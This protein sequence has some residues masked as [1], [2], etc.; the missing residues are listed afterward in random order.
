MKKYLFVL[1]LFAGLCNSSIAQ[2]ETTTKVK[3]EH[4]VKE[5]S[6]IRPTPIEVKFI[7]FSNPV[8]SIDPDWLPTMTDI[9]ENESENDELLERIKAKKN[10]LKQSRDFQLEN[11]G[12]QYKTTAVDTPVLSTN[13]IGLTNGG[14]NTPLDNT[15]AIA[16]SNY[17]VAFIN[18]KVAYYNTAGLQTN[19]K[20]LYTL[21]NDPTLAN[22]VCDPKVI[23]DNVAKR[24]IFF[25][26][27]C[28]QI[29]A[30]SKIIIGFSKFQNPAAGWYINELSGN[31]YGDGCYFD[32]PKMAVSSDELFVTG[33]LFIAS[34]GTFKKCV[35][36]Q[37][38][39]APGFAGTPIT[40]AVKYTISSAFTVLPAGKGQSGAY[41]PGIFM[42][43]TAGSTSGSGIFRLHEITN[44]V[45]SGSAILNT[46]NISTTTYS[47][48]GDAPQ[49]G[50]SILLNT[51]D[52]R[53]QDGFYLNG[54][55]HFVH[56]IDAGSGYSG[57][58]YNRV[59]VTAMSN[60]RSVFKVAGTDIVYPAIASS[61]NVAT[62][63]SVIIAFNQVSSSMFPRTCAV[64]CDAGMNWSAIT[65]VK[66]GAS[67]V[68]YSWSTTATDRWGDYTG[69]CKRYSDPAGS[70]WMAGMYGNTS[71]NWSQW[72]AKILPGGT[73]SNVAAVVKEETTAKVYPNPVTDFYNVKFD[74]DSRQQIVINITD[75]QGKVVVELYNEM[76][77]KGEKIFSFNR[78]NLAAGVY[79][80]NIIG[81]SINIKNERI[82][83]A[84]K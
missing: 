84:S 23:Y 73:P 8:S 4:L 33:N 38:P 61:S 63:K 43:S 13:F 66:P 9:S 27:V 55:V 2:D 20:S 32:Y 71:H 60:T 68:H 48:A 39:K 46:Y 74:L 47:P 83:V 25:A 7:G 37:I 62:D 26:Q 75:M 77:E 67:Y 18:S 82:V 64:A 3:Q 44:N 17:I 52:S 22:N 78:A 79:V 54:F 41:G 14:T 19:S 40:T 76:T 6:G 42:V 5:L 35:V 65:Q 10:A 53:A 30:N 50:S 45:A 56:N 31:P 16:D 70:V 29:P 28:D 49:S 1:S 36:Y 21:I 34:S 24:F 11:S 80:I 58:C 69:M 81:E 57:I 51:G 72:I 15:L 12:A 59:D